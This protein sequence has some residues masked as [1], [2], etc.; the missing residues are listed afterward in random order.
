MP[1]GADVRQCVSRLVVG[2][3]NVVEFASVEAYR[4]LLD[5]EEVGGHVGVLGVPMSSGL[6]DHQVGISVEKDP[7]DVHGLCELEA[8]RE[9]FIF[10]Y[11]VGRREVD[12]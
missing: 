8:V 7:L 9:R 4:K 10:S 2:A 1:E 6:L 11:V 3:V 5:V 12:L